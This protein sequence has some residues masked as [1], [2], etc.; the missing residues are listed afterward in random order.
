MQDIIES[1]LPVRFFPFSCWTHIIYGTSISIH[2][3]FVTNIN[4][5][6]GLFHT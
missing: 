6:R 5:K 4:S 1:L 2:H 3:F